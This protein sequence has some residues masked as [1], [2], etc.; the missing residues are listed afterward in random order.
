MQ[1]TKSVVKLTI[2]KSLPIYILFM[3]RSY[4]INWIVKEKSEIVG[5][6]FPTNKKTKIN[7]LYLSAYHIGWPLVPYKTGWRR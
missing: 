7:N 4:K 2:L 3:P 5:S 1:N 6:I